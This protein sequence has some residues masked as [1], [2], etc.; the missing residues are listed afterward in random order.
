MAAG[1]DI[2]HEQNGQLFDFEE[3]DE[4]K[5]CLSE[6]DLE[7]LRTFDPEHRLGIWEVVVDDEEDPI[8]KEYMKLLVNHH[9]FPEAPED[10]E[11]NSL[12]SIGNINI[13]KEA[14][15][16]LVH[17]F[18]K[19]VQISNQILHI[20]KATEHGI[21]LF[22]PSSK[23]LHL[24]GY[25][26]L[27]NFFFKRRLENREMY[28]KLEQ[29]QAI[30][31]QQVTREYY[32]LKAY[33]LID[34]E[35]NKLD[36]YEQGDRKYIFTVQFEGAKKNFSFVKQV[37]DINWSVKKGK[38]HDSR[39]TWRL[40][41]KEP[42]S[43]LKSRFAE[44]CA[45]AIEQGMLKF[46]KN[47]VQDTTKLFESVKNCTPKNV[48]PRSK[49]KYKRT[50][51]RNTM[52]LIPPTTVQNHVV[53]SKP[54]KSKGESSKN[55]ENRRKSV[56]DREITRASYTRPENCRLFEKRALTNVVNNPADS[57][58]NSDSHDE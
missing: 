51:V 9:F 5:T 14:E 22:N 17:I 33:D 16:D 35:L 49:P 48:P 29:T 1:G 6:E 53:I 15:A 54:D 37:K 55:S 31:A 40:K 24:V 30:L 34:R 36:N 56:K 44:H 41:N 25:Q 26:E 45:A 2:V 42:P 11:L 18:T 47:L 46:T 12:N 57:L 23:D 52:K 32:L 38:A 43:V 20:G 3:E 19:Y 8:C 21:T 27:P 39:P 28:A 58:E 7:F 10:D 13:P 50:N 4:A